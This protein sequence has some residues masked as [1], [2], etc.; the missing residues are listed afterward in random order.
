MEKGAIPGE[1]LDWVH[2]PQCVWDGQTYTDLY[3]G[4]EGNVLGLG[5]LARHLVTFDFPRRTMYLKQVTDRPLLDVEVKGALDFLI[6]LK[7]AGRSPGW[8]KEETWGDLAGVAS[9]FGDVRFCGPER[10]R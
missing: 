6:H 5:F 3:V 10:R 7:K 1:D 9:G 2:L 8:S 4:T